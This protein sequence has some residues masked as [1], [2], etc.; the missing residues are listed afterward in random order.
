MSNWRR[1][2][3]P[4]GTYCVTLVTENRAPIL[5]DQ[6]GRA[7][8]RQ[9]LRDCRLAWPFEILGI[10]LLPDHL[11]TLWCLPPGDSD[12]PRRLGWMK[13]EFTKAWLARG[14]AEQPVSESRKRHRRRGVLQR[15][16]WEHAIRCEDDL[17]R[18]LD[19]V[20]YNPVKHGYVGCARDWPWSSF[21]RYLRAG[22]YTADWG[23]AELDF[24]DMADLL[25]EPI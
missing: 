16:Y 17:H 13:K 6:T 14:G 15:K 4:G 12:Y 25:G 1:V 20:H 24:G 22:V 11:H 5:A 7:I 8:L 3:E 18:H 23:C 10:V 19:Y 2:F 21:H 9:T